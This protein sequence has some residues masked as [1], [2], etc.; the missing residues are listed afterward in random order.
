MARRFFKRCL[1]WVLPF[2][3][4]QAFV[5]VGFMYAVRADGIT[6]DFCPVQSARIVEL[7][8]R[9][10]SHAHHGAAHAG[11]HAHD[12]GAQSDDAATTSNS[13]PFALSRTA[14]AGT[15]TPVLVAVALVQVGLLDA[16]EPLLFPAS[17]VARIRIRGP[18][19]I[20]A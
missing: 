9:A 11:H 15:P 4:A 10:D 13:C 14:V 16:N 1:L 3:V 19:S 17:P 8:S 6:V 7:F 20:L 12:V 5:P 2:L 18:P